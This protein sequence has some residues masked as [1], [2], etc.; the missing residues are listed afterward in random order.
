MILDIFL[1]GSWSFFVWLVFGVGIGE[2]LY[3]LQVSQDLGDMR[4]RRKIN[5]PSQLSRQHLRIEKHISSSDL[6]PENKLPRPPHASNQFLNRL[7]TLPSPLRT[8]FRF[9]N[10]IIFIQ[11]FNKFQILIG[12]DPR[13]DDLAEAADLGTV[14]GIAW[15]EVIGLRF[16]LV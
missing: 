2:L 11:L 9:I 15:E 8:P 14:L 7:H 3:F 6:V 10:P 13:I 1:L 5:A 4:I 12:M 16:D